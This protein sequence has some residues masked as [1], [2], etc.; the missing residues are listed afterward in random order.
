[1]GGLEGFRGYYYQALSTFLNGVMGEEWIQVTLEADSKEDKIDILWEYSEKV[2]SIQV[3]SSINNFSKSDI[4]K[5][6]YELIKDTD[7]EFEN[8]YDEIFYELI[9]IGPLNADT[10]K[11]CNKINDN[12]IKEDDVKDSKLKNLFSKLTF[13]NIKLY[14]LELQSLKSNCM[15]SLLKYLE[16]KYS[17]PG[18]DT[19]EQ[20]SNSI[21]SE[22]I[23][24]SLDRKAF[25]HRRLNA[26]IIKILNHYSVTPIE[27]LISKPK[28]NVTFYE[29]G[30]TRDTHILGK[31]H[32]D[33][34]ALIEPLTNEVKDLIKEAL[35]IRLGKAQVSNDGK[36]ELKQ[37]SVKDFQWI[38]EEKP[39]RFSTEDQLLLETFMVENKI[40]FH[41]DD[42]NLGNLLVKKDFFNKDILNGKDD[43]KLKYDLLITSISILNFKEFLEE[44]VNQFEDVYKLPMVISN[45]GNKSDEDIRI[46]F[47]FPSNVQVLNSNTIPIPLE[48]LIDDIIDNKRLN[49][50]LKPKKDAKVEE[51]ISSN[52]YYFYKPNLHYNIPG[53]YNQKYS[54]A[55][56]IKY[57]ESLFEFEYSVSDG[58]TY[59]DYELKKLRPGAKAIFPTYLLIKTELPEVI[60][61][62]HITSK[63]SE[64][65][66]G[67][68]IWKNSMVTSE[69]EL[70]RDST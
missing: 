15:V 30:L 47:E 13:V 68:L 69:A 63:N 32:L 37:N 25:T 51:F 20:I 52:H 40:D 43:E 8:I 39:A 58:K 36:E 18:L 6:L 23:E 3:K 54:E 4:S 53:T 61:N 21:I 55:D 59:I 35:L 28:L 24:N 33:R 34:N 5:W 29:K 56:F 64:N 17:N 2:I 50:F 7:N 9:L 57:C 22:L 46:L 42:L 1:M 49:R 14:N 44:Y 67:T 66:S 12:T 16:N 60:F 65:I 41:K 11:F 10:T 48:F 19:L 27:H 26:K 31:M 45:E 70:Q 62:Y 38:F